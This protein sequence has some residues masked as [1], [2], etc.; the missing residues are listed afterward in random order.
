MTEYVVKI[1]FWLSAFDS[2]TIEADSDADAIDE[3]KAAMESGAFHE[4]I[5]TDERRQGVIAYIARVTPDRPEPV[6]EDVDF[7]DDRI[8][9]RPAI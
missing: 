6:V 2:L 9:A 8:H 3:A 5:D 7:D 4:H 1:G